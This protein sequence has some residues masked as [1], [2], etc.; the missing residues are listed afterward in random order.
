MVSKC[1]SSLRG[2][3]APGEMVGSSA[4]AENIQAEPKHH[5]LPENTVVCKEQCGHV[6]GHRS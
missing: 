3:G 4:G 1:H 2:V 5:V 6:K